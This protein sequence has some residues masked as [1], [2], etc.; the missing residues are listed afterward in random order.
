M[1]GNFGRHFV[2]G[3]VPT[4]RYNS[5]Y[6]AVNT[7]TGELARVT[8]VRR[9]KYIAFDTAAAK[10]IVCECHS[11]VGVS[12]IYRPG[13]WIDDDASFHFV[14]HDTIGMKRFIS[15]SSITDPGVIV[16]MHEPAMGE[17]EFRHH[18][19]GRGLYLRVPPTPL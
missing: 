4:P 6:C 13:D 19:T 11:C 8:T 1:K 15:L 12:T 17:T 9:H 3:A 18:H 7:G 5:V 10:N 14:A 2:D 16:R